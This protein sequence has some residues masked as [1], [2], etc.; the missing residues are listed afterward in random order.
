MHKAENGNYVASNIYFLG[1]M[2]TPQ[3]IANRQD[4]FLRLKGEYD[5]QK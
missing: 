4:T 1:R 3:E 5:S 2:E